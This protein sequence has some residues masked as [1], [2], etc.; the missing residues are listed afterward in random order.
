MNY[1][2][3][4]SKYKNK[5]MNL[6]NQIGGNLPDWWNKIISNAST[7]Q[8]EA[9]QLEKLYT[10]LIAGSSAIVIYLNELY[11][12]DNKIL[13]IEELSKLK[14]IINSLNKPDDLDLFYTRQRLADQNLF[15]DKIN[16]INEKQPIKNHSTSTTFSLN[17]I[18]IDS[19]IES[20]PL[21]IDINVFRECITSIRNDALFEK[22]KGEESIFAKIDFKDVKYNDRIDP[23]KSSII[24]G[25]NVFGL[26]NL[27][28][29]YRSHEGDKKIEM[30][31]FIK[32]CI[33]Q[34]ADLMKKYN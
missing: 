14:E 17:L 20:C 11:N 19:N 27:I 30:L 12:V 2:S 31:E 22:R 21:Y 7:I 32:S 1:H 10:F 9:Q 8:K 28:K 29:L 26:T 25:L 24:G 3:K 6:K 4:Y 13:T 15:Y 5:Y 23:Y 16:E 34:N 18:S 33:S